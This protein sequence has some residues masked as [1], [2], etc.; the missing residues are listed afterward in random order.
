MTATVL[1]TLGRLPKALEIARALN[2]AGCRVLIAEPFRRHV[3][4]PSR[5]VA[6]SFQVTAPATDPHAYARDL[7]DIISAEKVDFVVPVSEE[8]MHVAALHG[9]LP[10]R[11]RLACPPQAELLALH[12]KLQ[13]A[14]TA[15]AMGLD[16]PE[17]YAANDPAAMTVT[18]VRD[19]VVKPVHSCSG[20]GVRFE[21]AGS[22]QPSA[23]ISSASVVQ[24]MVRGRHVSSFTL[25][26]EGRELVTVLYEGTVFSGSVAVCFQRVDDCPSARSW[27]S[28]FVG[29]SGYSGAISFDFIADQ[30]GRAWAIE[31]NPRFTSGVHFVSPEGLAEALLDPA[32]AGPVALKPQRRFQQ[33]YSTLTEAYAAFFRPKEF[34]RRLGQMVRARDVVWQASDPMPFVMMTPNSWDILKPAMLGRMSMGEAATHD[35]V[36]T[37]P[38]PGQ[39]RPAI[40]KV[41]QN[42]SAPGT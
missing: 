17:T 4:S 27:I 33:G 19:Y 5:A 30:K 22:I 20:L 11:V 40:A 39:N 15:H 36:W 9:Q 21:R 35:I 13:F 16:V 2:G 38:A 31:C 37:G 26:H 34:V 24:A 12:D 14:R 18:A 10:P 23:S 28:S 3:C 1:L 42:A 29:K 7:L 6:Q 32:R 41:S 25:A 8:A